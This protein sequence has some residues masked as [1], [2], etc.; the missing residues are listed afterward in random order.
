M[1]QDIYK[2]PKWV[3]DKEPT[4]APRLNDRAVLNHETAVL[5]VSD[6]DVQIIDF[7]GQIWDFRSGSTLAHEA[8]LN[9][10]L[11][12]T[13]IRLYPVQVQQQFEAKYLAVKFCG[14][15]RAW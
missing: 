5:A 15:S 9:C 13:A 3:T 12:L 6:C 1:G 7:D 10:H 4:H 11:R 8:D 2:S 14:E